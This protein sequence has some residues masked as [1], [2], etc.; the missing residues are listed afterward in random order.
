[1]FVY[2]VVFSDTFWE[3]LVFDGYSTDPLVWLRLLTTFGIL[4]LMFYLLVNVNVGFSSSDSL[5]EDKMKLIRSRGICWQEK[6]SLFL[7]LYRVGLLR[8]WL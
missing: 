3:Y 7:I 8:I 6:E 2:G 5:H 1:M 4:I